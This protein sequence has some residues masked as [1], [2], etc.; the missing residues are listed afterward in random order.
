MSTLQ[1]VFFVSCVRHIQVVEKMQQLG[2]IIKNKVSGSEN[3]D[4][5]V[6][7]V[8]ARMQL[9]RIVR[10]CQSTIDELV[11]L[12]KVY[13]LSVLDQ[14]CVVWG[15]GLTAES[16]N[17]LERKQTTFAKLVLQEDY[18]TYYGSVVQ[19]GLQNME[20]R[21]NYLTLSFVKIIPAY[22][23]FSELFKNRTSGHTIKTHNTGLYEVINAKTERL[24]NSFIIIMQ[25]LLNEDDKKTC[26]YIYFK[27]D[28][29]IK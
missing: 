17:D 19:L 11:R 8:N 14:L 22:G 5:L 1:E 9:L 12:C 21:R 27:D 10:S 18:I 3:C 13:Y 28:R 15:S 20:F 23:H 2:P 6:K 24:N 16:S 7:K 29:S 25:K 4:V 26:I